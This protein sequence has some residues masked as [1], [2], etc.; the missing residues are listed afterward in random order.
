VEDQPAGIPLQ[1]WFQQSS[2]AFG[3]RAGIIHSLTD[4]GSTKQTAIPIDE[5]FFNGGATTVR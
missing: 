4:S 1:H 5:R 2:I 3:A